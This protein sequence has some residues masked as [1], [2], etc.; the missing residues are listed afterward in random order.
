MSKSVFLDFEGRTPEIKLIVCSWQV[1]DN[2]VPY[3]SVRSRGMYAL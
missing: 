2:L 3:L 1:V